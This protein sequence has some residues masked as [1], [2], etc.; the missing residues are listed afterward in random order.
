MNIQSGIMC[1]EHSN[2]SV[3]VSYYPP[4]C[5]DEENDCISEKLSNVYVFKK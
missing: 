1:F 5:I 3:N 2:N 4:Y